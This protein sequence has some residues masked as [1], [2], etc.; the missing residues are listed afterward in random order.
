MALT[1]VQAHEPLPLACHADEHGLVA[2]GMDLSPSR[3]LAA[4]REGLFPWYNPGDPVLWW[5]TDPRMVLR[6][7]DFHLSR[8]LRK[9][10]RHVQA[11]EHLAAPHLQISC[12]LAFKQ[13][14]EA[15]ASTR[16][17]HS[18]TWISPEIIE[19]YHAMHRQGYA[20]SLEAWVDGVL[21][22]GLYGI[23]VGGMFFGES[24]FS[25]QT[26]SSKI[27]LAYLVDLLSRSGM[28]WIDCQQETAHL[29]TLGARPIARAEFINE[30]YAVRDMPQK[31]W[32]KSFLRYGHTLLGG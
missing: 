9:K 13:V 28:S 12:N 31:R 16:Q 3:L 10:L 18:G 14:I 27:C 30:L 5:S 15:C 22:G 24:M 25:R 21:A 1:W 8:S 23:N 20:H 26:D 32:P 4:Y 29:A 6:T 19:T 2:A 17:Y 7:N 11:Q